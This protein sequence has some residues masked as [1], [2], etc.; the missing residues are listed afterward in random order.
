MKTCSVGDINVLVRIG[1]DLEKENMCKFVSNGHELMTQ[2]PFE[3]VIKFISMSLNS[4]EFLRGK[5]N[6]K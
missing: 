1:H 5:S 6:R 3:V 4:C 2:H